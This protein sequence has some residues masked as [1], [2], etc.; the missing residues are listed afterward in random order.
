[1][2]NRLIDT[3]ILVYAYDV[4]EGR[5]HKASRDI[6]MNIWKEGGGVVCLQNLME[7]LVVITSKV[8][9]PIKVIEAKGIIEDFLNSEKWKIIDR[10]AGTFLKAVNLVSEYGIPLWDSVIVACM[11]ENNVKEIVTENRKDFEKIPYIK[12]TVPF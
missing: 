8:E 4:F 6:I 1:M 11:K 5:K 7:F 10:D 3:N 12:V 2:A 9:R